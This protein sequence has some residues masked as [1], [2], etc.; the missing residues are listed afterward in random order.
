MAKIYAVKVG[1]NVGLFS[2]WADCEKE[3]KG[4]PNATYKS[5]KTKEDATNWL[6]DDI[7][8]QEVIKPNNETNNELICYIDGSYDVETKRYSYGLVGIY[9]DQTY[10][11]SNVGSN[12]VWSQHRNVAGELLGAMKAFDLANELNAKKLTIYHDYE[13]ISAWVTG[14][15]QAKN[16]MTKYYQ[17]LALELQENIELVFVKVKAHSGDPL[18]EKADKLAKMALDK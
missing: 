12:Q 4:Y 1:R 9:K 17:K 10:L 6:N 13:G 2:N 11:D 8:K 3:V 5:F 18:N 16:N 7:T 14:V 15:W